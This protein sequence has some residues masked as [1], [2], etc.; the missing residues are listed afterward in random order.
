MRIFGCFLDCGKDGT[1]CLALSRILDLSIRHLPVQESIL[2]LLTSGFLTE[3]LQEEVAQGI[4]AKS[5]ALEALVA[6]HVGIILQQF[7]D[8][9]EEGVFYAIGVEG[10]EQ[11]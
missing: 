9:A 7:R 8:P 11:Q 1:G 5:A 2:A 6:S 10:L 4:W 3:E